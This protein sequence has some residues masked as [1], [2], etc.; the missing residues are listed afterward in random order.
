M[1]MNLNIKLKKAPKHIS[2]EGNSL[3]NKILNEYCI[4]DEA[5][6]FILQTAMEAFDRMREAQAIIKAEGLTVLDRFDQKKAHPLTTV[7]RDAR[8]AM[9]QAMKSLNLECE[10][11]KDR[12][13]R[14][15]GR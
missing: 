1:N 9:M 15:D 8:S 11:L 6:L 3:W 13:G 10:P 2:K 5:G 4:Q 7:E 14:P 12:P